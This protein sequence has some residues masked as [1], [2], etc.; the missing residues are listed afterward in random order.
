MRVDDA[1]I[2]PPRRGPGDEGESVGMLEVWGR[3]DG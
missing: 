3:G 2:M 1:K